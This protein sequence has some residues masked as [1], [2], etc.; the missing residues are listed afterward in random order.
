MATTPSDAYRAAAAPHDSNTTT[1]G[2]DLDSAGDASITL[3][4]GTY[5]LSLVGTLGVWICPGATS[6]TIAALTSGAA[7]TRGFHIA[8][9]Q[10]VT[11]YHSPDVGDGELHAIPD[12]TGTVTLL[13]TRKG[14]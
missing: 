14:D 8:P 4:A 1:R 3:A 6:A 7:A 5:E 11:Y 9:G 10:V 12:D 13:C 2:L